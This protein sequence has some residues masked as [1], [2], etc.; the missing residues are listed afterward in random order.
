MQT[1]DQQKVQEVESS[2]LRRRVG[3]RRSRDAMKERGVGE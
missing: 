1:G 2:A 3:W